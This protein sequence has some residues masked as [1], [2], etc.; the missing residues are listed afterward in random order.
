M[1]K[2]SSISPTVLLVFFLLLTSLTYG[3][4]SL[5]VL[6]NHSQSTV[7]QLQSGNSSFELESAKIFMEKYLEVAEDRIILASQYQGVID[8]ASNSNIER[9]SFNLE[10]FKGKNQSMQF[11][12]RD[13]TANCCLKTLFATQH[14]SKSKPSLMPSLIKKSMIVFCTFCTMTPIIFVS[15]YLCLYSKAVISWEY[16]MAKLPSITMNSLV[17]LSRIESVGTSLV[18]SARR[19]LPHRN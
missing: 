18:K 15:N 9:L 17:R 4:I 7:K 2:L 11:A 19:S 16:Y 5:Y 10:R 3:G 14:Q 1:T 13:R 8:A 12:V 6:S